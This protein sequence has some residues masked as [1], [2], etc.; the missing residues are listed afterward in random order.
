MEEH[1]LMLAAF[2][3]GLSLIALIMVR[4]WVH[5]SHD[6][7]RWMES[8]SDANKAHYFGLRFLGVCL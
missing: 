7:N 1:I 8:A 3:L 6:F 4:L 2:K 5:Y